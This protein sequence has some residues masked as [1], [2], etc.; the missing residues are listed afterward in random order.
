MCLSVGSAN[1]DD[2]LHKNAEWSHCYT[3]DLL[4]HKITTGASTRPRLSTLLVKQPE[5][6][7][8]TNSDSEGSTSLSSSFRPTVRKPAKQMHE[9]VLQL[10]NSTGDL[11]PRTKLMQPSERKG[12]IR[13]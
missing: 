11:K 3:L 9:G 6:Y 7:G 13:G 2:D 1:R 4:W 12:L 10:L 8:Q 5:K